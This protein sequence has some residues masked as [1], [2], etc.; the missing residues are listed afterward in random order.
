M[1][2]LDKS[3]VDFLVT[4][5]MVD[6]VRNFLSVWTETTGK[7]AEQLYEEG[8][9]RMYFVGCGSSMAVGMAGSY[10]LQRYGTLAAGVYTGWEFCDNPPAQLNNKTA[11]VLISHSGKTEEIVNAVRA[12]NQKG[13]LT[14]G[15]VNAREGNPLG[16]E[17]K[18][19]IDYHAHA[20]WECHLL[21]V[22][23]LA[24]HYLRNTSLDQ[25]IA[26]EIATILADI[27][28]LPDVLGHHITGFE[29]RARQLAE[30]EAFWKGF[31]TIAAGPLRSLAYKEGIITSMEFVWSHGAVIES[32]EFRHGPLEITEPGVPFLFLLG[33]DASRHTT[34]RAFAFVKRY[35]DDYLVLDYQAFSM[36]LHADLAPMVM[37]VPLEWL[38][39]YFA[40]M[41]DHHP[42]QRRYY[43]IVA[44]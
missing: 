20:M 4:S 36:G 33:T 38:C 11:V 7:Y 3:T 42:D 40:V 6:E 28:K 10:L 23:L 8:I 29:E 31:Y 17:S 1:L 27:Q 26:R 15:I 5:S 24:L 18:R 25:E 19:V 43:N 35:T 32:G 14:I 21:S 39:Y 44:Y 41:K 2:T 34:E 12:A 9:E 22:Y 30:K 13:A 16:S 37:F